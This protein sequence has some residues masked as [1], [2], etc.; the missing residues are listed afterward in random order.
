MKSSNTYLIHLI[1]RKK[2]KE[3]ADALSATLAKAQLDLKEAT[4][5]EKDISVYYKFFVLFFRD[6]EMIFEEN[7]TNTNRLLIH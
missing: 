7:L 2:E 3:K 5:R 1:L 4:K 6:Q